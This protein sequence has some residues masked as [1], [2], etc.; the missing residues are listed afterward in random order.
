MEQPTPTHDARRWVGSHRDPA[1]HEKVGE[2]HLPAHPESFQIDPTTGRAYVNIPDARQIAV[3]D[4]DARHVLA[5]WPML[6]ERANFPMALDPAQSLL[7][8]V[9]RSPPTL[10]LM[11][12]A[13]GAVRQTLA[14]CADADDVFLDTRRGR[15][16]I[17]CGAGVEAVLERDATEWRRLDMVATATGARTSLFVPE[18]DR[19][20]VG[21]RAGLL[22]GFA[23]IRVYRPSS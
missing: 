2:I 20:F 10:L 22:K 1:S 14:I 21:Q 5:T 13:T 6:N 8:S 3:V 7:A 11:N 16:Y 4:L 19:L 12:L 15:A 9:F 18:I 23:A 17:S